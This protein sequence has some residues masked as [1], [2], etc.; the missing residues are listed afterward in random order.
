MA[1][2]RRHLKGSAFHVAPTS[3][4]PPARSYK[5]ARP[6]ADQ[7]LTNAQLAAAEAANAAGVAATASA[8][9]GTAVGGTQQA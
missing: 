8:V 7:P 3:A 9:A 1:G 5:G 2:S 4:P 6:K